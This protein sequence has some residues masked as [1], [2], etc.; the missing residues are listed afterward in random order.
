M[1]EPETARAYRRGCADE[2]SRV[3]LAVRA[4]YLRLEEATLVGDLEERTDRFLAF[5]VDE[6]E[7]VG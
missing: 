4:A 6:L 2:R 7:A 1:T 5:V 3:L